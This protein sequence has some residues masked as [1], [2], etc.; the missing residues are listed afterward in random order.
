M[1]SASF[2]H[3]EIFLKGLFQ[4]WKGLTTHLSFVSLVKCHSLRRSISRDHAQ[5]NMQPNCC[6]FANF[7]LNKLLVPLAINVNWLGFHP[8]SW[9]CF[10]SSS[11]SL[12]KLLLKAALSQ[13]LQW[14]RRGKLTTAE[15]QIRCSLWR[16]WCGVYFFAYKVK[17]LM[18][19]TYPKLQSYRKIIRPR[20]SFSPS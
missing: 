1:C 9:Y 2:L 4:E 8:S 18:I 7:Q 5:S 20:I 11:W 15:K 10:L 12:W 19:L 13:I 3:V 17:I 14:E 6:R 16:M